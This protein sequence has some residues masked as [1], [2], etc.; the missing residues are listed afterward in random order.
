MVIPAPAKQRETFPL[1]EQS[2][3]TLL[4]SPK[5]RERYGVECADG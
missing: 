4:A 5:L 3:K 1:G 2:G